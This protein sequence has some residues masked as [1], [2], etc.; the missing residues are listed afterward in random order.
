MCTVFCSGYVFL[1]LKLSG[2]ILLIFKATLMSYILD[3]YRCI[4]QQ[5]LGVANPHLIQIIYH[6]DAQLFCEQVAQI[7]A[8]HTKACSTFLLAE[9]LSIIVLQILNNMLDTHIGGRSAQL[10]LDDF[11]VLI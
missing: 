1:S 2:K 8:I 3:R 6:T 5:L 9:W 10:P 4:G 7:I 11:Q